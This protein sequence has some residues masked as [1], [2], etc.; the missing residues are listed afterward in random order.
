VYPV[1]FDIPQWVPILGGEPVTSFGVMMLL[2][3][4]TAGFLLRAEFE[5]TGFDPERAWDF[6]FAAVI[7]G[8]G[9][10]KIYYIFLNW[11]RLM[12]DPASLIFSRAGLVWYGGFLGALGLIL[13]QV[14]R[15]KLP[16][17][18]MADLHAPP[19]CI[20]YAVGRV[21]CFLVGDDYG[22]PT[23]GWY[24]IAFPQG[25][26]PTRVDVLES[27]F[28]VQVDPALVEQYGQVVPVHPTQLYEV[29]MTTVM[30]LIL[31]RLR[32]HTHRAGWLWMLWMAMAGAERF[33]V[34]IV[35]AKDDR[36]FGP[37]TMAQLISLALIA[38]GVWG[39]ARLWKGAEAGQK[40][41]PAA[42]G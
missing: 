14:R 36:F 23:D 15:Y 1:L 29:A 37:L 30:F 12:E 19:L 32:G 31:W 24:G 38:V 18:K 3:F 39:M 5:R 13:W 10:A 7:G 34:E 4:M 9:G 27:Y 35:R 8:I 42:T 2:S 6:V 17:G 40:P 20:A 41:A 33:L 21:G 28:G 26:P 11:P 22:R 16:L 25:S